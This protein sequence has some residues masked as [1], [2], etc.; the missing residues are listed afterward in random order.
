MIHALKE[1]QP[2]RTLSRETL[3]VGTVAGLAMMPLGEVFRSFDLRI[4]EYGRKTLE[5]LVGDVSG[6]L[7]RRVQSASTG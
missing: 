3:R 5:L 2:P 1:S 4:N 7:H 6:P